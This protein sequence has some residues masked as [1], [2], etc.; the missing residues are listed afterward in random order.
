MGVQMGVFLTYVGAIVLIFLVGKIFL[1]PL[2]HVLKLA[3]S[4]VI[5]GLAILI[6]N[7]LGAGFGLMIPLNLISAAIVGVLG[8]PGVMLLLILTLI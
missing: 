8:I 5:G 2:K 7:A 3:A 4:S 1:W 6:I